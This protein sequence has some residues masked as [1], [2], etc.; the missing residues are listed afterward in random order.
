M[1]LMH[2]SDLHLGRRLHERS[3][4][5]D[6]RHILQQL[7]DIAAAERPDGVLI[8]GDVY[9]KAVPSAEAVELFDDFLVQLAERTP[10]IFLISG[11]H[12]SP[13]RI[14]FGGR[15]M[16]SRGVHVSPV[17]TGTVEPVTVEDEYGPVDFW[18]LP[19]LKP[20]HVRRLFPDREIGSYT[21]AM[22]V[23]MEQMSLNPGRRNVLVTHQFVTGASAS[24]S[25]EL[26]VGGMDNVDAGVFDAFDYVALGHL[27]GPQPVSRPG[28]RYCGSP[29]KYSFAE[30][31][32]E[33]SVTLV[34]LDAD[35]LGG[36]RFLPLTPLRDLR[37]I[38]GSFE[39]LTVSSAFHSGA[40]EDYIQAILTDED[41]IPDAIGRLRSVYPNIL[42]LDYDNARTRS[43]GFLPGETAPEKAPL[44]LFEEFYTFINN[45]AMTDEQ[46]SFLR[47]LLEEEGLL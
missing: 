5:E 38:R 34:T 28:I 21:D 15:L 1:K 11:N 37:Q 24:G 10:H 16:D 9:D 2:L 46:R 25:E 30:T 39:E 12:D 17:Y 7:L 14:A 41:D 19:F 31:K 42:S 35:G 27:H 26:S 13:E 6:Q 47:G 18:L 8:A 36:I 32:Q 44:E 45:H 20:I 22:A 3:L 23:A 4:L 43:A 40:R 33:K 29:L